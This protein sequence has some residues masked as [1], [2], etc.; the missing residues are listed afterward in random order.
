MLKK[1][2]KI[3]FKIK[4]NNNENLN[5]NNENINNNNKMMN[6]FNLLKRKLFD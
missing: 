5:L 4:K 2:F 6:N 3:T 1:T